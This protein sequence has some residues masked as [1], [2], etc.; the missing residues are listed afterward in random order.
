MIT[1]LKKFLD[2]SAQF[3]NLSRKMFNGIYKIDHYAYR[4]FDMKFIIQKYPEYKVENDEYTFGN[5]VSA[6]WMSS[7]RDS[8]PFIFVSEYDGIQSDNKLVEPIEERKINVNELNTV[9][10]QGLAPSYELY[11]EINKR[12]QYLGWT[13]LFR[14][15][16]NHIAFLVDDIE[17]TCHQIKVDFPEYT[18]NNIENPI[19]VSEDGELLQ[20]SIMADTI[21]YKFSDGMKAV[22]FSF[23]EFVE[24][25]N[26]RRGFEGQNAAKIFDST[27][28]LEKV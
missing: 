17:E 28:L 20:F 15:Q 22:P 23:I 16:I 9:I 14:D 11:K 7:Q 21:D 2:H 10:E 25:K 24:R 1:S 26:G 4:S 5:N 13:I 8:K 27:K 19:Q 12:N 18:L 6:R 3:S